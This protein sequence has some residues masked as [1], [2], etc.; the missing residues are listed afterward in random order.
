MIT[1]ARTTLLT[2][3]ALSIVAFLASASPASARISA[4]PTFDS[5][6]RAGAKAIGDAI[7]RNPRHIRRVRFSLLPPGG[8]P[9]AISDTRLGS[10]PR[11]GKNFLIL[12][13]GDAR[14]A[15][16]RNTSD[17]LGRGQGGPF[18]RGA[19]DVTILRID[20]RVPRTSCL[21][22]RFRFLTEE[23]PEFVGDEFNDFFIAE[24]GDSTWNATS[25]ES[26]VI[27]APGNFAFG[28]EGRLVTV[29]GQ[30]PA[31]VS[32]ANARGTTYDG[33]TDVLRAS[34]PVGRGTRTL[35]L[36][37]GDQGDRDY[38]SA[39]FIDNLTLDDPEPCETGVV[40]DE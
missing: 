7:A 39:V 21:S 6:F 9:V 1:R 23:F 25:N 40:V 12:S 17:A 33:A 16:R 2:V 10:F 13:T 34:T 18:V 15:A 36:S 11:H 22:F 37:I 3:A 27:N 35:Y 5:Q 19:R 24:L 31:S 32:A 20:L 14:L 26:P 38:D 8:R 30:G 28:P 4:I 29:N